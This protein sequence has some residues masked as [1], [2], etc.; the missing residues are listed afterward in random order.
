LSSITAQIIEN[1][2]LYPSEIITTAPR[3]SD[4]LRAVAGDF[5]WDLARLDPFP[6]NKILSKPRAITHLTGI[7]LSKKNTKPCHAFM[8]MAEHDVPSAIEITFGKSVEGLSGILKKCPVSMFTPETYQRFATLVFENRAMKVLSHAPLVDQDL[9]DILFYLPKELRHSAILKHIISPHEARIL[10]LASSPDDGPEG[11]RSRCQF[12][13]R[14]SDCKNRKT[15]WNIIRE[16]LFCRFRPMPAP[17]PIDHP[18]VKRIQSITEI[19]KFA[20]EFQNCMRSL[21][22]TVADGELVFYGYEAPNGEK[23]IVSVS[24]KFTA[25]GPVGLIDRIAG[26]KN[27]NVSER[28][29]TEIKSIFEK[30]GISYRPEQASQ[31][32]Q[33]TRL[34]SDIKRFEFKIEI[35]RAVAK[36]EDAI[37][38]ST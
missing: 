25:D 28:V 8:V 34:I 6:H 20:I 30:N 24:P 29:L 12:A 9:I 4:A 2:D 11:I 21:V 13:S 33:M 5:V 15:F 18:R 26:P 23:A 32:G 1:D 10:E 14:L 38:A 31:L 27:A 3:V 35:D 37:Y 7:V 19:N 22:E 17:P 16:E 36:L